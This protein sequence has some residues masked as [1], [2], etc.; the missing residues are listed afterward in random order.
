MTRRAPKAK[1]PAPKTRRMGSRRR[2]A[3]ARIKGTPA[4]DPI[5]AAIAEHR[6]ANKDHAIKCKGSDR[7]KSS[8]RA[9]DLASARASVAKFRLFATPPTTL[10]GIARLLEYVALPAYPEPGPD[11]TIL[12]DGLEYSEKKG[13]GRAAHRFPTH[14]AAAVRKVIGNDRLY[15]ATVTRK[16]RTK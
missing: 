1:S 9:A 2:G 10:I 11:L 14:L 6:E 4:A 12:A 16:P 5:F 8:E 15:E 13:V 3:Q 7:S